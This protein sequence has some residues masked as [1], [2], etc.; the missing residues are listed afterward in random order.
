MPPGTDRAQPFSSNLTEK[1]SL[2]V[3]TLALV[4]LGANHRGLDARETDVLVSYPAG[5]A[6]GGWAG[7]ILTISCGGSCCT[8]PSTGAAVACAA[9]A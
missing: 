4:W 1:D 5:S 9:A 3:V 6:P 2:G 7:R 8:G